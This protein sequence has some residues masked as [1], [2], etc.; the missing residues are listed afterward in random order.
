M[1][2]L[3]L[4]SRTQ[5]DCLNLR[6]TKRMPKLIAVTSGCG[7][8]GYFKA[9]VTNGDQSACLL[10]GHS[11]IPITSIG[12]TDRMEALNEQQEAKIDMN[13]YGAQ[14]TCQLFSVLVIHVNQSCFPDFLQQQLIVV[15]RSTCE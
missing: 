1:S 12:L 14:E 9:S 10:G 6:E 13:L 7:D 11:K 15:S 3:G 2:D 8:P 4:P 5:H